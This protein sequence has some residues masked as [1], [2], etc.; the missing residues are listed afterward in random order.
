M[1]IQLIFLETIH[2][3]QKVTEIEETSFQTTGLTRIISF[4]M[5][6]VATKKREDL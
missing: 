1:K 5:D 3:D 6:N 4:A 2:N